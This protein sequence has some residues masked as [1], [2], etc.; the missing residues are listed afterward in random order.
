M[1]VLCMGSCSYQSIAGWMSGR[2]S[3][4]ESRLGFRITG[5]LGIGIDVNREYF[6]CGSNLD[7]AIREVGENGMG[8]E[9]YVGV[10]CD[11]LRRSWIMGEL[12][13]VEYCI[14]LPI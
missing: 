1:N 6:S 12:L 7:R 9:R 4:Y 5:V 8:W 13:N 2:I 10:I 14:T 3:W 11:L